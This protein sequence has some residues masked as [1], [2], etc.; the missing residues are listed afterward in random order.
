MAFGSGHASGSEAKENK[1]GVV[2]G[3]QLALHRWAFSIPEMVTAVNM[4]S[5]V[6][7]GKKSHREAC[8]QGFVRC[9]HSSHCVQKD[10]G[11]A[12]QGGAGTKAANPVPRAQAQTRNMEG[13]VHRNRLTQGW[14]PKYHWEDNG[15][16]L[17]YGLG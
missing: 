5:K 3:N 11:T 9:F 14:V 12:V 15:Q 1:Y 2:E 13:K 7:W 16:N 4:R 10:Q 17:L 6:R 8:V